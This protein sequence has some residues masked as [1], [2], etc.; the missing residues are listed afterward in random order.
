M[1]RVAF[2]EKEITPPLGCFLPGY[3]NLRQ[4]SNVKDRLYAKAMVAESNGETVA[5]LAID[6]CYGEKEVRDMIVDRI[7]KYTGIKPENVMFSGVHTHTGIPRFEYNDDPDAVENQ[8]E[9]YTVFSKLMAD[10]VILAHKRLE[11]CNFT[12]ARGYV[13]GISFCRDYIMKNSTPRTNPGVLNPDIVEPTAE[14]DKSVPAL[15]V[16]GN[17]GTPKGMVFTFDCHLDCVDGTEYSGDYPAEVSKIMKE[18]YGDDFVTLFFMGTAGN[19]NHFNVKQPITNPFHYRYMGKLLAEEILK[20]Q[21]NAEP[22]VG[23]NVSS[24]FETIRIKRR[25]VP[26]EDIDNAKHVIATVKEIPGIK[27]AADNTDP[28]Q[29]ALAMSKRL[30]DFLNTQPAEFDVPL[31]VIKIADFK[32]YAFPGEIFSHFGDMVKAG[33]DTKKNMVASMS[34]MSIGY[35]VAKEMYFDTIYESRPGSNRSEREAG[36]KMAE[37]LLEMGK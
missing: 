4:G 29:Y 28:D 11:E 12:F 6:G 36:Y 30:M 33:T 5:L 23:D 35:V 25:E 20:I 21:N 37:K 17:D 2:Y 7:E 32:L 22:L 31:Q 1:F 16:Y 27:I 14:I 3:F 8:R 26:Q 13:D 24:K 34:N 9:Y 15:F 10:C 19:I 18:K